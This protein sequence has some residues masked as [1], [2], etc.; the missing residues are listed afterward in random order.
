V[1]HQT[2]LIRPCPRRHRHRRPRHRCGWDLACSKLRF[3]DALR[4]LCPSHWTHRPRARHRRCDQ[5]NYVRRS[6]AAALART[7]YRSR[8]CAERGRK[9]L[10]TTRLIHRG[11]KVAGKNAGSRRQKWSRSRQGTLLAE[12]AT[13]PCV[14]A[15]AVVLHRRTS[16]EDGLIEDIV[17]VNLTEERLAARSLRRRSLKSLPDGT[18]NTAIGDRAKRCLSKG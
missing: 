12:A 15:V 16:C 10:I 11:T 4:G 2:L 7:F 14:T 18:G 6:R 5:L 3:S 17:D 9:A 1:I 8:H 13:P